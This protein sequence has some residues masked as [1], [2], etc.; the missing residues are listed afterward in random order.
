MKVYYFRK[1][2]ER[3]KFTLYFLSYVYTALNSSCSFHHAC[4]RRNW[5][6]HCI[7]ARPVSHLTSGSMSLGSTTGG[8]WT[9]CGGC[10]IRSH[11]RHRGATA[12]GRVGSDRRDRPGVHGRGW[13][14]GGGWGI[15]PY[16]LVARCN[17]KKTTKSYNRIACV[18]A[19]TQG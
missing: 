2:T 6:R 8:A 16:W 10:C 17:C 14:G 11:E 19:V 3:K 4:G 13:W 9:R 1:Q 5:T 15:G 7:I 12:G 18:N